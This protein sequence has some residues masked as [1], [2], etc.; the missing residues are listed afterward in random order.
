MRNTFVILLI[1]SLA[2]SGKRQALFSIFFFLFHLPQMLL[3]WFFF[4]SSCAGPALAANRFRRDDTEATAEGKA[5]KLTEGFGQVAGQ[6]NKYFNDGRQQLAT[7]YEKAGSSVVEASKKFRETGGDQYKK[8][9]AQMQGAMDKVMSTLS[10]SGQKAQEGA[11]SAAA[12][13]NPDQ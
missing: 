2:V 5:N 7:L 4:L 8:A 11:A 1:C 3:T 6:L 12:A 9:V 10:I 13:V